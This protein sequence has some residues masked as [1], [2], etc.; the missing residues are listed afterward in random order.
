MFFEFL[1]NDHFVRHWH[2]D[3]EGNKM[4]ALL[5]KCDPFLECFRQWR[6][7]APEAAAVPCKVS[8][9]VKQLRTR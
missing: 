5:K 1:E 2:H 8:S 9:L 7:D 3:A 4:C 6:L